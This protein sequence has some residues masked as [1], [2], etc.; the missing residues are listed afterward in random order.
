[1]QTSMASNHSAV[2]SNDWYVSSVLSPWHTEFMSLPEESNIKWHAKF[3]SLKYQSSSSCR[4]R[5]IRSARQPPF[6]SLPWHLGSGPDPAFTHAQPKGA[7]VPM[8]IP[9]NTSSGV[10]EMLSF[11]AVS[12]HV[13]RISLLFAFWPEMRLMKGTWVQWLRV[14]L[15]GEVSLCRDKPSQCPGIYL[16]N[17]WPSYK[18]RGRSGKVFR[19]FIEMLNAMH[20]SLLFLTNEDKLDCSWS[21][22]KHIW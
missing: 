5:S 22:L 13:K 6:T 10:L 21:C 12:S 18:H 19:M 20:Y 8:W 4:F 9:F 15:K 2:N 17:H 7:Q 1:M 16:R 14:L 3:D 11:L